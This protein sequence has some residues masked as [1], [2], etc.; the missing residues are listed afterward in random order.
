MVLANLPRTGTYTPTIVWGTGTGVDTST[1]DDVSSSYLNQPGLVVDG[2]GRD[3]IRAYAPGKAPSFDLTL[4]NHARRFSPGGTLA[5]FLGRGPAVTL[6]ETWGADILANADDVAAGSTDV[7][8]N[9]YQIK[10]LFDGIATA[11]PQ[12]ISRASATVQ[13][14]ALGRWATLVKQRPIIPLYEEIRTDEFLALIAD[15]VGWPADR[16][17]FDTGDT[18]ILYAWSNGRQTAAS[19]VEMIRLAEGA[20]CAIYETEDGHLVFEGRQY[21]ANAARSTMTQWTFYDG[22][23]GGDP[24]AN[25]PSVLAGDPNVLAN[26][27]GT[28]LVHVVPAEYQSNPD[29]VIKSAIAAVNVRTATATQKIWE[30]GGPLVLT[31]NEVRDL[32][33]ESPDPFKAAVTPVAAT[34]YSVSPGSLASVTLL[35]TS[36]QRVTLRLVAGAGGATVLGVTSAGIQLRAV[37]LPV[38]STVPVAST[39]DTSLAADRTEAGDL[40]LACWPEIAPNQAL[41]LVNSMALRY[42]RERRQ[43]TFR[44]ANVDQHHM[45]AMLNI[46]VSDRV[47]FV[48][49][50][51]ILNETYWVE[52]IRHEIAP[53][54]GLHTLTLGCER[55]FELIGG[56]YDEAR[57][58]LDPF[59]E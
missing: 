1:Y 18:T 2:I 20:G 32:Y 36:G 39:V 55:V 10:R 33:P 17:R 26:G 58:D 21:R 28:V 59:G 7:L 24:N 35:Q 19:L 25:D 40:D 48:H 46:R 16:R 29:E 52:Q 42:Q 13:V 3:Q 30:Y 38:T 6:D 22:G 23:I 54:G 57:Y 11:M 31:A 34:D 51:A 4:S 37:S 53:G 50:H 12:S 9:G 49:T 47:R 14:R 5:L 43:V 15:A 8:A 44:I 45:Y 56:T 41:D 27:T